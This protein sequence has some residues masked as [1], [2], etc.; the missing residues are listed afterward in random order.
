MT[1]GQLGHHGRPLEGEV[2]GLGPDEGEAWVRRRQAL[3]PDQQAELA[4]P[5]V[6]VS[7]AE[8]LRDVAALVGDTHLGPAA[9]A[10]S[11][12]LGYGDS[13]PIGRGQRQ[14]DHGRGSRLGQS[15]GR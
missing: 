3:P 1:V 8:D 10:A 2:V 7:R 11:G 12:H 4:G 13:T 6:D 5:V 14:V 9:V 15:P